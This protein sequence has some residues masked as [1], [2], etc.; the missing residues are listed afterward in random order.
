M[1]LENPAERQ[2]GSM[3]EVNIGKKRNKQ[4]ILP[5]K[6][7]NKLWLTANSEITMA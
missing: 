3:K 2:V 1:V 6:H 4:D 5:L 7:L